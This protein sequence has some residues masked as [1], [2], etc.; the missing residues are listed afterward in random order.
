LPDTDVCCVLCAVCCVLCAVCCVLFAV[1]CVL[2]AVC[3][4]HFLTPFLFPTPPA[5]PQALLTYFLI[6]LLSFAAYVVWY[7]FSE[8]K[9]ALHNCLDTRLHSA[10]ID[11]SEHDH[12]HLLVTG[13]A[14]N[15]TL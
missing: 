1:C 6:I 14:F 3:C 12:D 2:C 5:H 7:W 4:K 9:V 8:L 11:D 15:S 13:E 10:F